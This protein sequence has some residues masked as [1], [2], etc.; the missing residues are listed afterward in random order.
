MPFHVGDVNEATTFANLIKDEKQKLAIRLCMSPY[1]EKMNQHQLAR[2]F[3]RDW[4]VN[5]FQGA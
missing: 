3:I 5:L 2:E 1:L 4:A